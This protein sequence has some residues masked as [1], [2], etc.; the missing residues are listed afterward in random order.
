MTPAPLVCSTVMGALLVCRKCL[1][2]GITNASALADKSG[3]LPIRR[4][5]I[6]GEAC[7]C[8]AGIAFAAQQMEFLAQGSRLRTAG[9][10][11]E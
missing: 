2:A 9:G 11:S 6:A 8:P 1:G 10:K 3:D 4:Y 5:L 7:L